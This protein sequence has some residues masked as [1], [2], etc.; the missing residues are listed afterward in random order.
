M[1]IDIRTLENKISNGVFRFLDIRPGLANTLLF[2]TVKKIT[3]V[4]LGHS[5]FIFGHQQVA[6][7]LSRDK[8]FTVAEINRKLIL[9]GEF[10]LSMDDGTEYQEEKKKILR[11][12][13]KPLWDN[14]PLAT[15]IATKVEELTIEILKKSEPERRID[16]CGELA[17]VISTKVLLQFFIGMDPPDN[18]G[19]VTQHLTNLARLLVLGMSSPA[20]LKKASLE[21]ADEISNL[22][23]QR[24][25]SF[26]VQ[27]P[28][29]DDLTAQLYMAAISGN[30]KGLDDRDRQAIIS[31][32]AGLC[33]GGCVNVSTTATRA[34][35]ILLS[36]PDVLH[37]AIMAAH[38]SRTKHVQR[39][40]MEV[41]RFNTMFPILRRFC[42][43][44]TTIYAGS[45]RS[46]HINKGD[47]VLLVLQA[48][49]LDERVIATPERIMLDRP[50]GNYLHFGAGIHKCLGEELA[51]VQVTTMIS[52]I[53]KLEPFPYN[54]QKDKQTGIRYFDSWPA[55]RQLTIYWGRRSD[56]LL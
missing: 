32:I 13:G 53:L 11:N 22:V 4:R 38:E 7:I 42:V 46:I 6:D 19:K 34:M 17:E 8:E 29:G 39:Y 26:A 36:R 48:A 24:L 1:K 3:A 30:Q 15:A 40:I 5:C 35:S 37:K 49:M 18:V 55:A 44:D 50:M 31:M 14:M 23:A 51:M 52:E 20:K 9:T 25:D 16:F 28:T 12:L 33:L 54:L 2:H 43:R 21:S 27:A 41:L 47:T 45:A 56:R 10:L